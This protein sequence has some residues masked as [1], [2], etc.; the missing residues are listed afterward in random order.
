MDQ[1]FANRF[2]GYQCRLFQRRPGSIYLLKPTGKSLCLPL[3]ASMPRPR[4]REPSPLRSP[5]FSLFLPRSGWLW[6]QFGSLW[7]DGYGVD[8]KGQ[9]GWLN[10]WLKRQRLVR[11]GAKLKSI[12][13]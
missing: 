9:N 3:E 4:D 2:L 13:S 7:S 1:G 5:P 12:A 10:T 8:I 11:A 6:L